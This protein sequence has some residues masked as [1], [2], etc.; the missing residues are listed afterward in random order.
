LLGEAGTGILNL[1]LVKGGGNNPRK[2]RNGRIEELEA[3][4]KQ[5]PFFNDE[6]W[7][8]FIKQG[9][10]LVLARKFPKNL[11]LHYSAEQVAMNL[12]AALGS[13][14]EVKGWR[15]DQATLEAA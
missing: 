3:D 12:S 13:G 4:F 2:A 1:A 5:L 9:W 6:G 15:K 14:D 8:A 11:D 7:G 10:S